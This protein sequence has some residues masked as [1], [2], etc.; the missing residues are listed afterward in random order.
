M[1]IQI[2]VLENVINLNLI[3]L[4][5]RLNSDEENELIE[6]YANN[7]LAYIEEWVN[8]NVLAKKATITYGNV[9]TNVLYEIN[10]YNSLVSIK[11][12]NDTIP[13]TDYKIF[14]DRI[15][16]CKDFDN[17]VVVYNQSKIEIKTL[18]Q[19][20]NLIVA[21]WYEHR[22]ALELEEKSVSGTTSCSLRNLLD[23]HKNP[24]R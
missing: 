12:G 15:I 1:N 11:S 3:K 9:K 7:A 4:H 18:Q 8:G 22:E 24:V 17:V 13:E 2:E 5:L 21:D 16:F 6:M 10:K 14:N 20:I 23:M 19:C